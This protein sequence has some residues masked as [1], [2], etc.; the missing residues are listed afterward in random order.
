MS[1][2]KP[3][4]KILYNA[5]WLTIIRAVADFSG[6]IL[7]VV[8][9]RY[10]GPEGIGIYAFGYSIA[11][12][13]FNIILFGFDDFG[14]R[15]CSYVSAEARRVL[16]GKIVSIQLLL[17]V[18]VLGLF[19][20]YLIIAAPSIGDIIVL[21]SL[22]VNLILLAFSKVFFI[23]SN[24][25]QAM[26]FPGLAELLIRLLTVAAVSIA[27]ILFK[28]PLHIAIIPYSLSGVLLLLISFK[29]LKKYN[30]SFKLY[31]NRQEFISLVKTVWPFSAS[32][33]IYP[34]YVRAGIIILT[35]IMGSVAAGIYAP[36]QKVFDVGVQP[37]VLFCYSVYP[38]LSKYFKQNYEKF[39]DSTEKYFRAIF[40]IAAILLWGIYFL[41]PL[42]IVPLLGV[43]FKESII[44][45]KYFAIATFL[46]SFSIGFQRLFLV[47]N[48][49]LVRTK[50]QLIALIVN[51]V[52]DFLL[53]PFYGPKGAV[54]AI[55]LSE[56]SVNALFI[57]ALYKRSSSIFKKFVV[58]LKEFL[59][60][61]GISI[62]PIVLSLFI[63]MSLWYIICGTII[64]FIS[65]IFIT[66]FY[67][68][69][70]IGTLF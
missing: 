26:V 64:L 65:S 57:Y 46:Y 16:I 54:I 43:E 18:I 8:L 39:E 19:S 6:L 51:L 34:I 24:A 69:F 11:L 52:L 70:D 29:S 23:P 4:K 60:L 48:L 17:L 9:S 45:V 37:L 50:Y 62:V 40:I 30:K 53:I 56:F 47:S 63:S 20:L 21:F 27:T 2:S 13:A 25:Q 10:Y 55:I 28:L 66:G 32:L 22:L 14:I 36:P 3:Y 31:Y 35:F 5:G 61:F 59:I 42:V 41:T 49:Q 38:V 44:L 1:A 15:E 58:I 68:K 33:L 67:R 12:I 7:Y